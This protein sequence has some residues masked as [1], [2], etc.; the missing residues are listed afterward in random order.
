MIFLGGSKI[1]LVALPIMCWECIYSM[2]VHVSLT[3]ALA[4]LQVSG[5]Y[6]LQS[7]RCMWSLVR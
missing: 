4:G 7:C 6:V 1:S 3:I 2:K 5:L